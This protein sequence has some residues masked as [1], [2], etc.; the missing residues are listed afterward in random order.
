[1]VVYFIVFTLAMVFT[2]GDRNLFGFGC[3]WCFFCCYNCVS[4]HPLWQKK[5]M[6]ANKK[7]PSR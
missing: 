7:T 6:I 5:Q 4:G 2:I 1:M 3:D